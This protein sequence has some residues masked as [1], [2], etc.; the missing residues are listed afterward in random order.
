MSDLEDHNFR[1]EAGTLVCPE[2]M[3]P[4]PPATFRKWCDRLLDGA[5]GTVVVD[6]SATRYILSQHVGILANAWSDAVAAGKVLTVR[7]SAE[8][9]V[10]LKATGLASVLEIIDE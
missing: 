9:K 10:V 5:D 3:N 7:A 2:D 4:V 8:V 1:I 6:L